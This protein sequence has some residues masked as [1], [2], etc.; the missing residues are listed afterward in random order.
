[1]ISINKNLH[2]EEFQNLVN[3]QFMPSFDY[4]GT[5]ISFKT[6]F[7]ISDYSYC[8]CMCGY[9][10]EY[11][12]YISESGKINEE[13]YEKIVKC[14]SEGKCP[15][16]DEMSPELLKETGYYAINIAAAVG[17]E[18][19]LNEHA[20]GYLSTQHATGYLSTPL[21]RKSFLYHLGPFEIAFMKNSHAATLPVMKIFAT[22]HSI[23]MRK[24]LY[25]QR[26]GKDTARTKIA[27]MSNLENCI[28]R[29]NQDMVKKCIKFE[30]PYIDLVAA[31][32]LMCKQKQDP[33]VIQGLLEKYFKGMLIENSSYLVRC[34]QV[35]ILYNEVQ[36]LRKILK[37]VPKPIKRSLA[38]LYTI[39]Y[40]LQFRNCLVTLTNCNVPLSI[41]MSAGQ[42]VKCL[43]NLLDYGHLRDKAIT[44]LKQFSNLSDILKSELNFRG[45]FLHYYIHKV[46]STKD[47]FFHRCMDTGNSYCE[48]VKSI[49]DMDPNSIS[50]MGRTRST[51]LMYLLSEPAKFNPI[52]RQIAEILIY[53]NPDITKET[54]TIENGLQQD[55]D[56]KYNGNHAHR[57]ISRS[58]P[59]YCLDSYIPDLNEGFLMDGQ[60]HGMFGFD[61]L[62]IFPLNFFVPLLIE[63]GFPL[64]IDVRMALERTCT[65]LHP[66]ETAY[67]MDYLGGIRPLTLCCRDT[68]RRHYKG[69]QIQDFVK[70]MDMP[71]KMRDFIL[72]KTLLKC[73]P[74]DRITR[75]TKFLNF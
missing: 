57:T 65:D 70:K 51:P 55:L 67:I 44:A 26:M 71:K 61:D 12:D 40:I 66:S 58:E 69:R 14:L 5:D 29:N 28:R 62:D 74:E 54:R 46:I 41:S 48:V 50:S 53:E 75:C 7:F 72:L 17:T 59:R 45:T 34:C 33:D 49:V 63:A 35:S 24:H 21:C 22:S 25:V 47:T 6:V 1:M 11:L 30:K 10:H 64:S 8:C 68:L 20:T 56:M 23:N 13:M 15:H 31:I 18:K 60:H 3:N 52:M 19:A 2:V 43:V 16:V 39:C 27:F 36:L 42:Q 73:I 9:E 38:I 32:N 4:A 37:F